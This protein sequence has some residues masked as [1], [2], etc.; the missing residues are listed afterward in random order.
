MSHVPYRSAAPP[1]RFSRTVRRRGVSFFRA[2]SGSLTSMV[3]V[4]ESMTFSFSAMTTEGAIFC[5]KT[6]CPLL[7]VTRG[8]SLPKRSFITAWVQVYFWLDLSFGLPEVKVTP[9]SFWARFSTEDPT[10]TVRA[11]PPP[12]GCKVSSR[13]LT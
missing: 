1:L 9:P 6:V 10:F 3:S 5:V 13:R 11:S 2:P 7:E 4:R 8:I 12:S